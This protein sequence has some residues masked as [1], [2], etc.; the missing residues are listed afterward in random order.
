MESGTVTGKVFAYTRSGVG[1]VTGCGI[2]DR[3]AINLPWPESR[4]GLIALA[5]S[6]LSRAFRPTAN[7]S[8]NRTGETLR[9]LLGSPEASNCVDMHGMTSPSV[10]DARMYRATKSGIATEAA[11][12]IGRYRMARFSI[13]WRTDSSADSPASGA[14]P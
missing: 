10:D 11:D 1:C 2:Y 4:V 7:P 13:S 5:S 8:A 14:V 9:N 12:S 3:R 6:E